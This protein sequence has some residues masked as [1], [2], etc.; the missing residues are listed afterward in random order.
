HI[1]ATAAAA[2]MNGFGSVGIIRGEKPKVFSP[3]LNDAL[4]FGM[5]LFFTSR[6]NYS[7]KIVP[8][9]VLKL[10]NYSDFYIIPEGGYGA[11]GAK[12]AMEIM[13]GANTANYSH[14]LLAAG[15]GT[16]AAGLM[17]AT[18][19]HQK[20]I[21]IPVLKNNFSLQQEIE[22]LIPEEKWQRLEWFPT[23]HF[24]GY[25]KHT[26]ELLLFM[27]DL[28]FK[29]NIPTDFVYT[30]KAF[31][32]AFD[33]LNKNYFRPTDTLLI[34]HTGGLQGNRSLKKGT[35]IFE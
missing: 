20:I 35:L 28:Y 10:D 31:Y 2:Q 12:G 18:K 13:T 24:G 34:V 16:T 26:K 17:A 23:Y 33:L 25:A 21:G 3:S 22:K 27:N 14:I 9:E 8:D 19:P 15:T 6:K 4:H 32:A 5:A 30:A 7:H 11:L 29:T 1:V